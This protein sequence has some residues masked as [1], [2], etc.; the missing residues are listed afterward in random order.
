MLS[1]E[2][3]C[4]MIAQILVGIENQRRTASC[5]DSGS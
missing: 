4:P 2:R 1:N 3:D 5:D